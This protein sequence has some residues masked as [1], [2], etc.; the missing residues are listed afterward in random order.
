MTKLTILA[1]MLFIPFSLGAQTAPLAGNQS[2]RSTTSPELLLPQLELRGSTSTIFAQL[3]REAGIS[4]GIA[5]SEEGCSRAAERAISIAAGTKFGSAVAQIAKTNT[6][7]ELRLQDGVA[8]LFPSDIVPPLLAVRVSFAWD[9]ATPIRE[10]VDRLRQLPQI[11]KEAARQGLREAP[12]EG[13]ST[14]ICIRNCSGTEASRPVPI[15]QTADE[16]P[17][18]SVLNRI[19]SAHQ[20]A[21]WNYEEHQCK[22]TRFFSITVISE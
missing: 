20:G 17:L 16:A 1:T 5:A 14:S 22:D 18:L 6:G 10:V 9:D 21:V 4:G 19:A 7:A 3:V 12:F 8:N 11:V 13:A 15:P 2:S